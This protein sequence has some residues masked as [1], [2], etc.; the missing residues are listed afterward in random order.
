MYASRAIKQ[1]YPDR[2]IS[3]AWISEEEEFRV[4]IY[5]SKANDIQ[6]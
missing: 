1:M 2:K 4:E 3:F 5:F 6:R